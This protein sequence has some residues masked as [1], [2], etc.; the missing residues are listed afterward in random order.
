M[1]I[2]NVTE[3][4][5]ENK[6]L[7]LHMRKLEFTFDLCHQIKK[8]TLFQSTPESTLLNTIKDLSALL[9]SHT[10]SCCDLVGSHK[11]SLTGLGQ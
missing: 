9:G 4:E 10:T 7:D 8:S 3:K 2:K 1:A 11:L 6:D 5:R